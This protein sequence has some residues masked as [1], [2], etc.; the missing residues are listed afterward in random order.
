MCM[1]G[2]ASCQDQ[3]ILGYCWHMY[4]MSN[5][6]EDMWK[7]GNLSVVASLTVLMESSIYDDKIL[8]YLK[9][10]PS[11]VQQ[12]VSGIKDNVNFDASCS[13]Y[14]LHNI[15]T[16]YW[17]DVLSELVGYSIESLSLNFLSGL[18]HILNKY[19]SLRGN[20]LMSSSS[21]DK[22]HLSK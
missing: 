20:S 21:N 14:K 5:T 3:P 18:Y 6:L 11:S 1:G 12:Y 4:T 22:I 15:A 19:F 7:L 2:S 17:Y 8:A 10:D 13:L 9:D 16:I